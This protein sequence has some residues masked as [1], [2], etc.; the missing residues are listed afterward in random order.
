M[1]ISSSK[2]EISILVRL[3]APLVAGALALLSFN[4]PAEAAPE[5]FVVADQDGYGVA[6]CLKS[7]AECGRIVADAWC[8]SHG[9]GPASAYGRAEDVTAGIPAAASRPTPAP[10]GATLI[11]CSD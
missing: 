6:D 5:T 4:A 11:A 7:G 10:E 2:S 9:H 3:T 1:F 8:E